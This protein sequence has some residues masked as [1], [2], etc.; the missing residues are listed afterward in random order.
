LIFQD[1]SDLIDSIREQNPNIHHL[2]CSVFNGKYITEGVD[3]NYFNQLENNRAETKI[4]L[5]IK[6]SENLEIYNEE[7]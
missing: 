7:Q 6:E 1:L 3:D 4:P 2:E 5:S